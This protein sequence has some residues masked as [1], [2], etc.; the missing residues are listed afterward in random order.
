MAMRKKSSWEEENIKEMWKYGKK[1]WSM[2]RELIG[3]EREREEEVYV[4]KEDGKK[5]EIT[6]IKEEFTD[7]WKAM[8]YQKTE[9]T[10]FSFWHGKG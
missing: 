6:N 7:S 5:E 10:D 2:I 9:K 4:Y 1:F 8:V 3:K